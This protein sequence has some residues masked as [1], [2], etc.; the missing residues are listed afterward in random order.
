[1]SPPSHALTA[2]AAG[3]DRIPHAADDDAPAERLLDHDYDGIREYD[4]PLPSW[5]S[6]VFAACVAFALL[7]FAY[8][9]IAG[10]GKS[11]AGVRPMML[12][13]SNE[14]GGC[15]PRFGARSRK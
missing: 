2:D 7:Y 1:M 8:Y 13:L 9:D 14:K 5:W 10:W 3:F 6:L 15:A 12:L 11:P 4:N